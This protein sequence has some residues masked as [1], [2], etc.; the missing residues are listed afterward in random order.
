MYKPV[1]EI[2]F[3][4]VR[5]Q[6]TASITSLVSRGV[7]AQV[8]SKDEAVYIMDSLAIQSPAKLRLRFKTHK[9]VRVHNRIPC[10]ARVI[11]STVQYFTSKVANFV[12]QELRPQAGQV[13]SFVSNTTE[14][15]Q[16]LETTR[17]GGA[18]IL[19]IADVKNFFLDG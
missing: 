3:A 13:P 7:K 9:T 14:L 4:V 19:A 16:I 17:V 18:P 8:L 12:G 6:V 11:I 5:R 2:D 1:P 10:Q 15:V